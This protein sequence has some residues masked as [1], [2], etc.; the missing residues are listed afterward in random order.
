M[1]FVLHK[2]DLTQCM[3][4]KPASSMSH[5]RLWTFNLGDVTSYMYVDM[6]LSPIALVH[7]SSDKQFP[8]ECQQIC[9]KTRGIVPYPIYLRL[10]KSGFSL[11]YDLRASQAWLG[12]FE[13]TAIVLLMPF[14]ICCQVVF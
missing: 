7:R 5:W 1:Q 13:V 11:W 3:M 6:L 10:Q 12:E 9:R 14:Q 4:A 2:V 8:K